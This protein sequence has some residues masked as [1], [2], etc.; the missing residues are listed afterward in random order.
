MHALPL[1]L[2]PRVHL[3]CPTVAPHQLIFLP[4]VWGGLVAQELV[5]PDPSAASFLCPPPGE[6][7]VSIGGDGGG[8][9]VGPVLH[10]LVSGQGGQNTPFV[11]SHSQHGK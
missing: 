10:D 4:L 5:L 6:G 9:D 7:D 3:F 2:L 11:S 1:M 8:D